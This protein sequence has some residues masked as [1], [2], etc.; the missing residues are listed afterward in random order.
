MFK[1]IK[2]VY[3]Q[4]IKI[5]KI[6]KQVE[7]IHNLLP[8]CKQI[9]D[10]I[11]EFNILKIM[12][13]KCGSLYVKFL[14][15]Y[16]SKLKSNVINDKIDNTDNLDK[17]DNLDKTDNLDN[18][19]NSN[20]EVKNTI[21]FINYFE[22]IFED[23]PFHLL[24]HTKEIFKNSMFGIELDDYIDMNSLKEYASGS[25]GQV[26]YARRKSDNKEIAIKVKHP[27]IITDLE[28]Q[29]ELIKLLRF[30][31]SFSFIRK[32]FN[33]IFNIDDFIN[34]ISLQC[35]FCNEANN[36]KKFRENFRE[37]SD[38]IVFPEIIF[39]SEDVLISE[40]IPGNSINTLTDIQ[41]YQITL[42][43]MC[44][45]YQMLF[46]DNFIHGD[47]HCKNWK[48][49]LNNFGK[50]QLII[51]DCGICFQNINTELTNDFWFSIG[52]YDVDKIIKT[53]KKFITITNTSINDEILEIEIRKIFNNILKNA[54][55]TGFVLKSLINF[56]TKNNIII[57]KF[58]LNLSIL[59][60]LIEEFLNKNDILNREKN[61]STSVPM[62]DL[63]T[64]NQLDLI[65]FC[66]VNKCYPQVCILI[67]EELKNKYHDYKKNAFE[68]NINENKTNA[69]TPTL[70]SS[71]SLS[72]L[73]FKKPE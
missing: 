9:D 13:F 70:F 67:Q 23:C 3:V 26:Y 63:I 31:Q 17:P 49:R 11:P 55:S 1:Y 4:I 21:S 50:P 30:L 44:F 42:N 27:D 52:K 2:N 60:C 48:V 15:W 56:F 68:N 46:I 6:K 45:F 36:C 71:I 72:G 41:K 33:L 64:D 61:N 73:K 25:I 18:T 51:Y 65:S 10:I 14:Q 40:F 32:H 16:I 54:V 20:L 37:S 29:S 24:E 22:D 53:I 34:N 5:Y 59:I 57:H 19:N 38:F 43:F 7:K 12:I 28:N 8:I 62:F 58:L 47:L 39:Q 35:D 69:N 66:Q